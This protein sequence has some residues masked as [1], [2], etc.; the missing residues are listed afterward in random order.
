M[1]RSTR[2]K[3]A[4]KNRNTLRANVFATHEAE[5]T[6]RLAAKLRAAADA[7][8]VPVTNAEAAAD[9]ET[10]PAPVAGDDDD[11]EMKDSIARVKKH[12]SQTKKT[13]P[14]KSKKVFKWVKQKR[15][16]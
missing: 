16:R 13:A 1:A 10:Q 4:I 2:S 3:A 8:P 14:K 7:P 15:T 12:K 5:R 6:K 9:A 11:V